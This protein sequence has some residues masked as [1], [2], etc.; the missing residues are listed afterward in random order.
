MISRGCNRSGRAS[1]I[2]R[3]FC[4]LTRVHFTT[5]AYDIL[6]VSDIEKPPIDQDQKYDFVGVMFFL[7]RKE[8]KLRG[9][10]AHCPWRGRLCLQTQAC[11]V[12]GCKRSRG[13][14]DDTPAPLRSPYISWYYSLLHG[15]WNG[16]TLPRFRATLSVDEEYKTSTRAK[17]SAAIL[18]FTPSSFP[19]S[20]LSIQLTLSHF[21]ST[22]YCPNSF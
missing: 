1:F 21:A 10:S 18:Q 3:Y 22:L 2:P 17:P 11:L 20:S 8:Q 9:P 15:A 13:G 12:G 6:P 4:G 5:P 16:L 14:L 19:S 7:I